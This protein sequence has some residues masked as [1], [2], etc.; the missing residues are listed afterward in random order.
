MVNLASVVARLWD[1]RAG[2]LFQAG[3]RDLSSSN[4]PYLL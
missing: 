4:F 1:G 3:V 2:V